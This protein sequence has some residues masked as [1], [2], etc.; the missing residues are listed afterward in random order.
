MPQ[1]KKKKPLS[2]KKASRK[3]KG[4][5]KPRVSPVAEARKML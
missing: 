5:N 2:A 1:P 3:V 4:S